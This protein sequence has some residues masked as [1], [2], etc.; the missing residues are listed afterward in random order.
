MYHA[1]IHNANIWQQ[2]WDNIDK[3]IN[4]KLQQVVE[5]VYLKQQ[6]KLTQIIKTQNTDKQTI[7]AII[8][9]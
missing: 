8:L 1:H 7:T 5:K 9:E 2:T 4:K 6:E 3:S